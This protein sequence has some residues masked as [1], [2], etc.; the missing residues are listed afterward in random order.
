M[1]R[2]LVVVMLS[3]LILS[4]GKKADM[5]NT[6][7]P[8]GTPPKPVAAVSPL[9]DAQMKTHQELISSV[10]K[11]KSDHS[12]AVY[13]RKEG[14]PTSPAAP[15]TPRSDL[16]LEQLLDGCE[17][18]SSNGSSFI[19]RQIIVDGKSCPVFYMES[20]QLTGMPAFP[21]DFFEKMTPYEGTLNL[22]S[23]TAF[24][25]RDEVIKKHI[26]IISASEQFRIAGAKLSLKSLEK[27][28]FHIIANAQG[29][30]TRNYTSQKLGKVAVFGSMALQI[31]ATG[32][33]QQGTQE[34]E[35]D[36]SIE[37]GSMTLTTLIQYTYS[38]FV[39][40]AQSTYVKDAKGESET[41]IV[42][43]KA[44]TKSV[45]DQMGLFFF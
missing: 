8:A 27:N 45:S 2:L 37:Q 17:Q 3:Q 23:Q 1:L 34:N 40:S 43:G 35:E 5:E 10:R 36:D 21:A 9:T 6:P 25:V 16:S 41:H 39:V 42:N 38:D 30:M 15:G 32:V 20:S 14:K 11:V 26:D 24:T 4:C 18:L 12:I 22:E 7:S 28:R 33:N 19:Q 29:T 31:D 44:V 13:R